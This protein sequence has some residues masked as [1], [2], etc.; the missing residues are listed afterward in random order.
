MPTRYKGT[1]KG[2]EEELYAY[3]FCKDFIEAYIL[4]NAKAIYEGSESKLT[5]ITSP[6]EFKFVSELN[7]E[8][9][10]Y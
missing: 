8:Q 9:L 1:F 4:L 10:F 6:N 2:K 5:K 7:Q 3:V